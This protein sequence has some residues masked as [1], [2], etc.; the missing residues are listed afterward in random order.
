M[1]SIHI[2][3]YYSAIKRNEVLRHATVYQQ[4]DHILYDSIYMEYLLE[5]KVLVLQSCPTLCNPMNC[6]LPGSSVHGFPRQ[7]YWSELPFSSP[8]N[9]P[10]PGIELKSPALQAD[11][12]P[13]ESL[14]KPFGLPSR[15]VH[16][17]YVEW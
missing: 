11:S 16:M 4:K 5:L 14:K 3:E 7:E 8:G 15:E 6:N 12:A 13:S 9:L 10:T 2:M 17:E 1:W